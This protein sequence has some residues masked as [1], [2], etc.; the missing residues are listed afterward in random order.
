M[1]YRQ[2]KFIFS[3]DK[4][5]KVQSGPV[6]FTEETD[7]IYHTASAAKIIDPEF[8][9][10]ILVEKSGSNSTVV[11]NPW[12]EKSKRMADFGDEEYH[13]M[14]CVE[15]ANA[16]KGTFLLNPGESHSIMTRISEIKGV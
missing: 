6:L 5:E 16:G 2:E 3:L 10:T 12:V 11:W 9:R 1:I 15:T 7:R 8:Y 13:E 14:L 4:T